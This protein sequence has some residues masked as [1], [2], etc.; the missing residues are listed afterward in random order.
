[1]PPF[2]SRQNRFMAD[3]INYKIHR[4]FRII[5]PVSRAPVHPSY[6]NPIKFC[7]T[8]LIIGR[9]TR[10]IVTTT[11]DRDGTRDVG[12][13]LATGG[14]FVSIQTVCVHQQT[15]RVARKADSRSLGSVLPDSLLRRLK[16]SPASDF[17]STQADN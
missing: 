6:H 14:K 12:C 4:L 16:S 5:Q 8:V 7:H 17:R 1:M 3:N 10:S 13:S 15:I 9:Q 11:F 2:S